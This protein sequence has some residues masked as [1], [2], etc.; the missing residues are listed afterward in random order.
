MPR[1]CASENISASSG[2]GDASDSD[3]CGPAEEPPSS[4]DAGSAAT[5]GS[6][7]GRTLPSVGPLA[8]SS[9]P[10]VVSLPPI[11]TSLLEDQEPALIPDL[12]IPSLSAACF[13][14]C[15]TPLWADPDPLFPWVRA[16]HGE[17]GPTSRT[18]GSLDFLQLPVDEW[19]S[20]GSPAGPLE[21]SCEAIYHD[22]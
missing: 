14:V 4:T 2:N 16:L 22:V 10:R 9:F 12:F 6:G 17:H 11:P 19:V 8:P 20:L 1:K 7:D 18:A 5:P 3:D 15:G 13:A 21:D